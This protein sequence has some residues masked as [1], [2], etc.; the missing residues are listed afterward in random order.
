MKGLW[1]F[2]TEHAGAASVKKWRTKMC[3]VKQVDIDNLYITIVRG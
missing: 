3:Y 1:N 2:K